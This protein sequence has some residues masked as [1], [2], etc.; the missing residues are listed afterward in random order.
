MSLSSPPVE[1]DSA[2]HIAARS[3]ALFKSAL[4]LIPGG[5]SMPL[6]C[7]DAEGRTPL[8]IAKATGCGVT[9]I[10]GHEYLDYTG[11]RGMILL[12]HGD[13]R[14]VVAM[15]KAAS[16][17]LSD[18]LPIE[19]E[20]R[21]AELIIS[22]VR[23]VEM[24]SL[25]PSASEAIL[26]AIRIA[27]RHTGRTD[28]VRF[29]GCQDSTAEML[30]PASAVLPYNDLSAVRNYLTRHRGKV[31]AIVLE[32]TATRMGLVPAAEGFLAGLRALCH[33]REAVLI[34]DETATAFRVGPGGA[35]DRLGVVP[36]LSV[37]G[38]LIGGG[39]ALGAL[40]GRRDL[41]LTIAEPDNAGERGWLGGNPLAIAAGI[42]TLQATADE[43]FYESLDTNAAALE[44]GLRHEAEAAGVTVRVHRVG[45]L[46]SVFFTD[47][48]VT[49][50]TTAH[51]TDVD[52][53]SR[54]RSA[55]LERGVLLPASPFDCLYTSAA[56]GEDHVN[57]TIAAAADAFKT[58]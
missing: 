36:D 3:Q 21:L 13:Q 33:K 48:H 39:M 40:G 8:Y 19:S 57:R 7:S 26:L 4:G 30:T 10:D 58:V 43:G 42:A 38:S 56:H 50:H 37:Y 9:D 51:A 52:R 27:R 18:G 55:L 47:K 45:S 28:I 49:D 12:G 11:A 14:V 46:L 1:M 29:E 54:W 23:G 35:S 24:V 6:S 44:A 25:T 15:D 53:Y 34:F 5:T 22:R 2:Q 17:G 20:V 41:M 31:A 16:K 32:P